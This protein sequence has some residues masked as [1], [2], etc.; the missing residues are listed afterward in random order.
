[1]FILKEFGPAGIP[2]SAKDSGVISG[3]E[4]VAELGLGAMELEFVQS[5][6]MNKNTAIKVKEIANKLNVV[7]TVHAPYYINFNSKKEKIII[8]SRKRLLNSARIGWLAGAKSV[9][10]HAG[11]YHEDINSKVFKRIRE[12]IKIIREILNS[13]ENFIFLAPEI[14]GKKSQFGSLEEL[15][16]LSKD[17]DGVGKKSILEIHIH[18][19]GIDYGERGEIRHKNLKESDMNYKELLLALLDKNS[20]GVVICESPNLEEDALMLQKKYFENKR[21]A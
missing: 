10:F 9:A 20:G 15:L 17:I 1:M 21:A 2:E 14:S 4:R 7:L 12:E 11:F 6:W 5:V 19:S 18:I 8:A 13:E 16:E 3:I